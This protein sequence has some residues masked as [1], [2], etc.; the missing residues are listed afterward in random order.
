[1]GKRWIIMALLFGGWGAICA[2]TYYV[3]NAAAD[4]GDGSFARP[5]R[6]IN[7]ALPNLFAGDTLYI[8]GGQSK[9][10]IYPEHLT[11]V[12]AGTPEHPIVIMAFPGE[13][14]EIQGG[15]TTSIVTLNKGGYVFEN[16]VFNH[17]DGESDAIRIK[18]SYNVLRNCT[19]K[20]GKRDGIDIGR[21]D[22]N[23]IENCTLFDFDTG[24]TQDAHGIV[25]DEGIGTIIRNNRIFDCSGDCI[26]IYSGT[27]RWTVIENNELYTTLGSGSEN[28]I[29]IKTTFGVMILGNVMY[30]FRRSAGSQGN[31]V[32]IHHDADS[33]V[34]RDNRIYD[35][36][37]GIRI[38][39]K[40]GDWPDHVILERNLVHD[41][42]DEG[43]YSVDGYAIQLD[44][45]ADLTM[46]N[47]TFANIPGPLFWIDSDGA[48]DVDI[49]NNLFA[50]GREFHG[51]QSNLR[52]NV[53]ID[54]NGWFNCQERFDGEAHPIV[55]TDPMFVDPGAYDYRLQ[56]GSPAID[57]GDPSFGTNYPGGRID[58]GAFEFEQPTGFRAGADPLQDYLLLTNYPNPFNPLTTIEFF[59]PRSGWVQLEIFNIAGQKIRRLIS[60]PMAAG[61]HRLQWD[62]T[63]RTGQPVPGGVYF[64]RL[65]LENQHQTRRMVLLR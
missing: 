48:V 6:S 40:P 11:L 10:Q 43:R 44:G 37:G 42:V 52:G 41:L 20:N 8:R 3:D 46:H 56:A 58:L 51:S 53:L 23:I 4:Q 32:V 18:S 36:N 61:T 39:G 59:L 15:G 17:L 45:L 29:D 28:A 1:M 34:M 57:A 62:A 35:S 55:G 7:A 9:P 50:N 27:A 26:Q 60:A 14:V 2:G 64:Y 49:R 33:V 54:Y 13:W 25:L 12:N 22:Y 21:G 63:D 19:I 47:N 38:G 31:A 16:L 24:T 5:W 65:I 30:G